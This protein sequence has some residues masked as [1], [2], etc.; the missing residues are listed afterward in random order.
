MDMFSKLFSEHQSDSETLNLR[1]SSLFPTS[2]ILYFGE[3][4]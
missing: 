2:L 4:V 1:N 3:W